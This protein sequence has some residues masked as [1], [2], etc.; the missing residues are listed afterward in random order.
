MADRFSGYTDSPQAPARQAFTIT[1]HDSN[2]IDPLPKAILCGGAGNIVL[3]AVDSAGTVTIPVQAGQQLDIRAE[4][5][6]TGTT[7][8]NIVGLA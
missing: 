6:L 5:V 3:K 2:V 1:P 7:A 4:K 8:T